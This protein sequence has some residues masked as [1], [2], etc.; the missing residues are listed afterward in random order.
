MPTENK[1]KMGVISGASLALKMKQESPNTSDSDILQEIA[2]QMPEILDRI[3][4]SI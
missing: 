2:Y 4:T 3:D 1:V